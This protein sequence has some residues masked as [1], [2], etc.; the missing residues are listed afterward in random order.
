MRRTVLAVAMLACLAAVA[1]PAWGQTLGDVLRRVVQP[2]VPVV[3]TVGPVQTM[4]SSDLTIDV[5]TKRLTEI[6]ANPKI[7]QEGSVLKV[8]VQQKDDA[9]AI[10]TALTKPGNFAMHRVS[11]I[12]DSCDGIT[13]KG[14]VCFPDAEHGDRF[15]L[16][17][18]KPDIGGAAI[19][20]A[21]AFFGDA[22][23]PVI[24]FRMTKAAARVFGELTAEMIGKVVAIVVDGE[25]LTA[26]MIREPI[27]GGLGIISGD[28]TNEDA[29]AL[30]AILNQPPLPEPL[31]ILAEEVVQPD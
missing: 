28:F 5:L 16:V 9:K 31:Q 2:P 29:F 11:T 24:K 19:A 3:Y 30:A 18:A 6:G 27:L 22:G 25:V 12:V 26:P 23:G 8:T 21:T 14:T 1:V 20:K 10:R 17:Q 13:L 4:P 15:Y 7:V